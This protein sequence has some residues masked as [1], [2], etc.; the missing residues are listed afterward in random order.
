[1]TLAN[2]SGNNATPSRCSRKSTG[3]VLEHFLN[4]DNPKKQF[5]GPPLHLRRGN[6]TKRRASAGELGCLAVI[7]SIGA[8]V[9][10]FSDAQPVTGNEQHAP[11]VTAA[12][13]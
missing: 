12:V 6:P 8:A 13:K 5:T 7:A 4:G 11:V 2:T 1:M 9:D 3:I 10:H